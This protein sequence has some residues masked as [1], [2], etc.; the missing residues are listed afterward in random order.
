[1]FGASSP[2]T[3]SEI[4]RVYL[5]KS[6]ELVSDLPYPHTLVFRDI[7]DIRVCCFVV[8]A[9]TLVRPQAPAGEPSRK[10]YM[11]REVNPKPGSKSG[12]CPVYRALSVL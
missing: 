7:R 1:M 4:E 8:G 2:R 10:L 3:S 12:A 9:W 11:Q 5:A 6:N